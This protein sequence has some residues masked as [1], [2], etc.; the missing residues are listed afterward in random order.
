[1][2]QKKKKKVINLKKKNNCKL[3]KDIRDIRIF[4]EKLEKDFYK[5]KIASDI[6]NNDHIEYESNSARNKIL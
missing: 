2:K 1:M 3:M 5:P 4:S 6:W